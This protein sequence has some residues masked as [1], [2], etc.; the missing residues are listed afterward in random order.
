MYLKDKIVVVTGGCGLLGQAIATYLEKKGALV[1]IADIAIDT[2]KENYYHLD[3]TSEESVRD[4]ISRIVQKY[5]RIDGWVNNAF[6]RTNDWGKKFEEV[7]LES[8]KRNVDMHLNGYFICCQQIVEQMKKQ[9]FGSLVNFGS[10]YGILGPDF[11]IYEGTEMTSASAYSA[12][13]GGIINFTR[14][15]ASYYGKYKVRVNAISPGGVFDNQNPI[16]VKNYEKNTP[17]SRMANPS[18][19]APGVAFLL[20]DDAGYITGHNLVID[21]GW[22]AK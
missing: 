19:I 14:Y 3:I 2:K 5:G 9:N 17:L 12:I 11:N 1:I 6:P 13:K 15:L 16:F 20:S 7:S 4:L 10:I 21:G 22:T 18:D 8:W